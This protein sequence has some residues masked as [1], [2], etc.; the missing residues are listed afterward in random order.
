MTTRKYTIN[1]RVFLNEDELSFY[2]LGAIMSDGNICDIKRSKAIGIGSKDLDWLTL[3]RNEISPNKPI[4]KKTETHHFLK[5]SDIESHNWFK[6][7]GCTPN[8]SLSLKMPEI[9]T[10][11]LPDFIRG[12]FDGDGSISLS[13]YKKIKNG[14]TYNYPK[15]GCYICS[16]SEKFISKLNT[17]LNDVGFYPCKIRTKSGNSMVNG[18][19]IKPGYTW[20]VSFSDQ[21]AINFTNWTHYDGHK[22]SMPRKLKKIQEA[23]EIFSKRPGLKWKNKQ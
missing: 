3:I 1:R 23:R 12:Y 21:S 8:K 15:L 7:W 9:P 4:Y 10:K 18:K 17:I 5:I 11:Y 14:K 19:Y 6:S 20:R 22:I 16:G 2:L 13:N